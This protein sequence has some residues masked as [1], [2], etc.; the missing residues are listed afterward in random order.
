MDRSWTRRKFLSRAAG[1]A[2]SLASAPPEEVCRLTVRQIGSAG[3][4]CD[5]RLVRVNQIEVTP[6]GSIGED[7]APDNSPE[8]IRSR[9]ESKRTGRPK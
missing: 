2:A 5:P 8:H 9:R 3:P 6:D 7:E 1:S 4:I